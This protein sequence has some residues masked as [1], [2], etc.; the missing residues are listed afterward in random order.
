MH[1]NE[2]ERR[3]VTV[4]SLP[5]FFYGDEVSAFEPVIEL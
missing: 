2:R 1:E 5:D 4:Q 3:G